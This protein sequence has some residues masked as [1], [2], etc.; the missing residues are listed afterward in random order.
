MSIDQSHVKNGFGLARLAR[1]HGQDLLALAEGRF[2]IPLGKK[3][4]ALQ[5]IFTSLYL[6]LY[7]VNGSTAEKR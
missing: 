1:G 5:E 2:V 7:L 6:L 3:F 4:L